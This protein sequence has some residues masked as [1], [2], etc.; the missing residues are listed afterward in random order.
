MSLIRGEQITGS[1]AQA[2][3]AS[4]YIETDPIFTAKSASLATTGSNTFNGN[5]TIQGNI[6][7]YGT[8]SVDVFITNYQSSSIIYSSGS[9][10]FGDTLDDSHQF[11]GSVLITG[12]EFKYNNFNV[13][14]SSLTSSMTVLSSSYATTASYLLNNPPPFP[15]T[16]SAQITGSLS[17]NGVD[18]E[19]TSASFNQRILNNSASIAYLSSSFLTF[20]SSY[21]TASFTG[22]FTGLLYGTASWSNNSVTSSYYQETDPIFVAKSASLATT[23]SN[24]FKGN[25]TISGS[26]YL[27]SGSVINST[28][29]DII[30]KAGVGNNAGV[31]LYNNSFTQYL[32]VDDTGS[33]ANKFTVADKL[34]IAGSNGKLIYTGTTTGPS[35]TL[36]EVHTNDDYPWLERFYNDTFSTS[37][38]IMA[39]FGWNDGRFVFHNESTQSIGLQV[40][41]FNAENG[42]LV[43]SDKVAFINNV[44]ITGSLN[45]PSITGSLLGTASYAL[46][47]SYVNPLYQN[48]VITGSLFVTQSHI[49][50]VD[51]ID[52]N[53]NATIPG[54]NTGRLHWIDDTKT[55]QLDT[56]VNNFE[57]E[58]GHQNVVRGRN[59][60]GYTLTKGMIVYING[61]SGNRPT[62]TTASWQGDPS[63]ASTLGFI[64]QDISDNQTGYV[65]TSGILRGINT[66][67]FTPGTQLY[68]SSS[69]QYTSTVPISPNHEVRL[70]K[71]ITQAINGYI[72]VDIMNGYELGELH[73]VLINGKTNGDLISWD[74]GSRVWKNTKTLSGSYSLSGSLTT[75]GGISTV[76]LTSS[77]ISASSITGSLF[78]TSSWALNSTT[79]S[80]V[81]TAQTASYVLNAVSSSYALTASYVA[82]ASSFPFT[83][84]AIITGSL[85]VSG[86]IVSTNGITGSLFGT[87]S[88][89]NN[90]VTASYA[91]TSSYA[92]TASYVLQAVSASYA[93]TSSYANDFTI[94]DKLYQD[95]TLTHR[96]TVTSTIVGTNNLYTQATGSYTSAFG[97]YTIFKDANARAGEFMTVW[98]GT[99]VTYTDVST[100]DIGSTSTIAFSSAVVGSNIQINAVAGSS[101]WKIK[102]LT[103]FI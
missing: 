52:F 29:A 11:T 72:Y 15:Y 22:S 1:V 40:N 68:L 14:N 101:G 73:D 3:T 21:N 47:A 81:Q 19:F 37:S 46:T 91:A 45:A 83:G 41:G 4:Y 55:L 33:Y 94:G 87:A 84:S 100:T 93:A 85:I 88:W 97:K 23:G 44:E 58:I 2:Q 53:P 25:Q 66:N 49:S 82:N 56:D 12:S 27:N 69:G 70:G 62:F 71:T 63:S 31:A 43:Y 20:S 9:T 13:I 57:L 79:A 99:S 95:G 8:A 36:A 102:M 77:F 103:T 76:S 16:G 18:Y 96:S 67:A 24:I 17:I 89:A 86:S 90:S 7:V 61:E 75:N 64:A 26:I 51:Y 42:L 78:G 38:A 5:Q 34:T 6:T 28:G 74:S 54:F 60:T 65:V 48:V 50:T 59:T 30:I 32:A 39:Y 35:P 92:Q 80:F 10:K 98:N